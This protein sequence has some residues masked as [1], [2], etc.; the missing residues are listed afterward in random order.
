MVG[1]AIVRALLARR[2]PV[3]V[4]AR[5]PERARRLFGPS[6]EIAVGDL[7]APESLRR[8]CADSGEIYHAA[9]A[10]GGHESGDAEILDTNVGGTHRLL[11]AARERGVSRVV[12]TSSVSVY[13]DRLPLGVTEEAPLNPS[14][15]YGVSKVRAERLL[16]DAVEGGLRGMIVRPCMVYGPEDRYFTLQAARTVRLP[17]VPLPDGGRHVLD[18]VHADDLAAAHLLVMQAGQPG[19]AYNVT[20]GGCY[21]VRE[22]IRWMSEA[23]NRSPWCP[24]TPSW[25]AHCAVPFLRFAGRLGRIPDLAALRQR[26]LG[27]FF[28][29]Y[30][31]DISKIAALGFA[32]RIPARMGLRAVLQELGTRVP[33]SSRSLG[34]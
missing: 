11:T 19:E 1:G 7:G 27:E 30:H 17:L 32:P 16:R 31:F 6:V 22:L 2:R 20:D 13:G 4:L 10:L 15:I 28:S 14:A 29:D 5:D 26:D 25:A 21:Q 18:V 34:R 3:R 24:A 33:P 8:A 12:Y 23:L 9:A